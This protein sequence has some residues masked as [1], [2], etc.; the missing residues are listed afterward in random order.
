M[1][2]T[3]TL[4]LISAILAFETGSVVA[5]TTNV[6]L[7]TYFVLTGFKMA[8]QS[9]AI[10]VRILNKDLLAALN[11]TGNFNFGS[12]AQFLLKSTEDQ[13]PT[14]WV[15]QTSGGQ[16]TTTDVSNYITLSEPEE[17]NAQNNLISYA[18]RVFTFDD[19]RGTSFSVTG[20]TTMYRGVIKSSGVG[21][22][23]RVF[24]AGSQVS[25]PGTIG[26]TGAV[27][28]GSVYA[29]FPSVEVN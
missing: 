7:R 14:V 16:V 20:F 2:R 5:Q 3:I 11:A 17:V 24:N 29:G 12:G 15:R 26:G 28:R 4:A 9:N 1:K 6:Y 23:V 10:P 19:Q 13:L 18:I 21:P 27:L 25:G 8:G 22:L